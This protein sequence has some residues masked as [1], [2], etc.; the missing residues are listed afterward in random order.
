MSRIA[1][2]KYILLNS[3][4]Y[5]AGLEQF[6]ENLTDILRMINDKGVPVIIRQACKQ[7]KRS[8][9]FYFSKYILV[10]KMRIKFMKKPG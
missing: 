1:K 4:V 10:I 3:E 6:K 9:T 2:D 5:N 7:F 8:E